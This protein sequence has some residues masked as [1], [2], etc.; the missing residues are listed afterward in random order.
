MT[1]RPKDLDEATEY[2]VLHCGDCVADYPATREAWTWMF[3]S[4]LIVCQ[5]CGAELTL[6][7]KITLHF[8]PWRAA[9]TREEGTI[10][11]LS[12]SSGDMGRSTGR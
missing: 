10:T 1:V 6:T 8:G 12:D 3:D 5:C 4:D 2:S 9:C 7:E 11:D